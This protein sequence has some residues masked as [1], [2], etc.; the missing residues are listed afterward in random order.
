MRGQAISRTNLDVPL[1]GHAEPLQGLLAR[2]VG[3]LGDVTGGLVDARDHL[4]LVLELAVL[5]RD[6]AEDRSLRRRQMLERLEAAGPRRVE[7]EAW[8]SA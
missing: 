7:L 4:G 8:W 5:G 1:R 6:D 3:A 2:L